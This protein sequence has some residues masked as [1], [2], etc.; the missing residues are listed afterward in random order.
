MRITITDI[1]ELEG[2]SIVTFE[3][4]LGKGAARWK[5][6]RARAKVAHKYD[7]EIDLELTLRIGDNCQ[8]SSERVPRISLEGNSVIVVGSVDGIDV[9]GMV[10]LRLAPDCLVMVETDGDAV[11]EAM[12]LEIVAPIDCVF[13]FAA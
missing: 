8:V 7:V 10:Y 2:S 13:V 3:C 6:P 9:D 1:R 12:W 11:R 4:D 5:N